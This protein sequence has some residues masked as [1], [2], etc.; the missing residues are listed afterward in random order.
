[1]TQTEFREL[2]LIEVRKFLPEVPSWDDMARFVRISGAPVSSP[3]GLDYSTS[4][5]SVERAAFR[6]YASILQHERASVVTNMNAGQSSVDLDDF[7]ML[8]LEDIALA[9]GHNQIEPKIYPIR[10]VTRPSYDMHRYLVR[11]YYWYR[12]GNKVN[13]FPVPDMDYTLFLTGII[14]PH[15]D[16]GDLVAVTPGDEYSLARYIASE[17]LEPFNPQ[18]ASAWRQEVISEWV[19][20]RQKRAWSRHFEGR[21]MTR[22]VF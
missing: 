21:S 2:V 17:F 12:F 11:R 10:V 16:N 1:M 3:D 18:V 13:L 19:L 14:Y 5:T 8:D 15:Y 20:E 9:K 6:K 4:M 22:R 7:F